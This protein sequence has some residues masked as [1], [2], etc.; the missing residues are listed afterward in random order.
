VRR[1]AFAA[2]TCNYNL[3]NESAIHLNNIY[4][5][6]DIISILKFHI[7]VSENIRLK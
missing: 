7:K 6:I 3:V 5:S 2:S 4:V 1:R